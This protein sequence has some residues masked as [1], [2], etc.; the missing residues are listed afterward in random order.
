MTKY[1]IHVEE[2][3]ERFSGRW[4]EGMI[5]LSVAHPEVAAEWNYKKNCGWGPEDFSSGSSIHCFWICPTCKQS[6]KATISSRTTQNR[7][8]CLRCSSRKLKCGESLAERHPDVA[9][10][11]YQR[12][13]GRELPENVKYS[14][15]KSACWQCSKC[16]QL[17]EERISA[18]TLGKTGCPNCYKSPVKKRKRT[19]TDNGT[20]TPADFPIS[21]THKACWKCPVELS[22]KYRKS[23]YARIK[24]IEQNQSRDCPLC[25]KNARPP[26]RSLML[27]DPELA[28]EWHPTK[29]GAKTPRD[30]TIASAH[31]AWW[32]CPVDPSHSYERSISWRSR[33]IKR[34]QNSGCS[35]CLQKLKSLAVRF[36][37]VAKLWHPTL[38]GNTPDNVWPSSSEKAFWLCE[39]DPTHSWE[40]EIYL[41]SRGARCPSCAPKKG[42]LKNR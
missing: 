11:W 35:L 19:L 28:A 41:V 24:C 5:Q 7:K 20:K 3:K 10:E 39:E 27:T 30:F 36:P 42:R 13:N 40:K 26:K 14:S 9:K 17:W 4:R 16:K 29:N 12:K 31:K 22:H 34:G 25:L 33:C 1:T 23:I 32:K 37:E 6:Y 15:I 21:S 8:G 2:V 18:R 38:N